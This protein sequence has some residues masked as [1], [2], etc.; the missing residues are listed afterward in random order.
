MPGVLLSFAAYM[1]IMPV[2]CMRTCPCRP[3]PCCLLTAHCAPPSQDRLQPSAT[4]LDTLLAPVKCTCHPK[5]PSDSFLAYSLSPGTDAHIPAGILKSALHVE[6]EEKSQS[7]SH[8]L[9]TTAA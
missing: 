6:N 5:G 4:P 1:D 8:Q 2:T 3:H 9:F 7:Q